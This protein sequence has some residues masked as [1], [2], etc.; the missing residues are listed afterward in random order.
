[1]AKNGLGRDIKILFLA[2]LDIYV[3][4]SVPNLVQMASEAAKLNG[5]KVLHGGLWQKRVNA[6]LISGV[7]FYMPVYAHCYCLQRV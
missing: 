6:I 1:M 4:I 2:F 5:A 3:F 7:F